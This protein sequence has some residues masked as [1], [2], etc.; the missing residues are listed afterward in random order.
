MKTIISGV[1]VI[2]N[3]V[4]GKRYIGSSANISHREKTHFNFLHKGNHHNAHLQSSYNMYGKENFNFQ[5]LE[6]CNT[7]VLIEREQFYIDTLCPEY[8]KRLTADSN[9]GLKRSEESR[10][11]MSDA[12]IGFIPWNK[13]GHHTE[14]ANKK[15]S[16]SHKGKIK[17]EET[18]RK[19]SE[20][21]KKRYQSEDERRKTSEANNGHVVSEKTRLKISESHKARSLIKRLLQK[22]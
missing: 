11:K 6:Y 9:L 22:I 15:N 17:S 1:Y 18:R 5:I 4:N 16:E 8:N 20:A 2:T 21:G 13:G 3:I 19:L 14:E 12:K 7:S 10:K